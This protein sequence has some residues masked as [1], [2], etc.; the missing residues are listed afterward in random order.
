MRCTIQ[1]VDE[2]G[3]PTPDDNEAVGIVYIKEHTKESRY[4]PTGHYHFPQSRAY[5]I[6]EK[7]LG[8]FYSEHLSKE[9]WVFVEF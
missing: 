8:R 4:Y 6:C 3:D 7:H 1:W 9:H 5:P 2:N